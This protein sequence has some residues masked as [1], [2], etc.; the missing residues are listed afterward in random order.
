[1]YDI[2]IAEVAKL[3]SS[4]EAEYLGLTIPQAGCVVRFVLEHLPAPT[5][6]E[7]TDE[8]LDALA[9]Q[10]RIDA[11]GYDYGGR[12]DHATRDRRRAF[13]R[14]LLKRAYA[15]AAN[16]HAEADERE[17]RQLYEDYA[18]TLC[19]GGA[20]FVPW[21]STSSLTRNR[22]IAMARTRRERAGAAK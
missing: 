3:V 15:H 9:S 17:A 4:L 6:P 2:S 5:P 14:A 7:L 19:G 21:A 16:P 22:W 20:N 18:N 10:A 8:Q 13:Q 11:V 1:M 12:P